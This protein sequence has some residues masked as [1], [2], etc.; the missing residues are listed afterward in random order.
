MMK[1]LSNVLIIVGIALFAYA[2][3]GRFVNGD[4]VFGYIFPLQAKTAVLG[5]N[6]LLLI[7]IALAVY[8]GKK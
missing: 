2:C 3:I 6:S 7:G 5:A 8:S 1:M 4:T